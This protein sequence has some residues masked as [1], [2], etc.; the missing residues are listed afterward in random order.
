MIVVERQDTEGNDDDD[1]EGSVNKVTKMIQKSIVA[2]EA[3]ITKKV[4]N[5]IKVISKSVRSIDHSMA[6]KIDALKANQE[7][8]KVGMGAIQEKMKVGMGA[9][10][11]EMKRMR[12]NQEDMKIMLQ[13]LLEPDNHSRVDF[14]F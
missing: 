11:E 2:Q 3:T 9:N 14:N 10:Q 13:A 6:T 7:E 5:E 8:M 12:E 1:W 4:K